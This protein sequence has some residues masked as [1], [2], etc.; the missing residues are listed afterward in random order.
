MTDSI[1]S[2]VT[3]RD[4]ASATGLHHTT[5]SLGLRNSPKL[6]PET[7]QK[8]LRAAEH[9]GYIRDPMLSALNAYR[10][11][12]RPPHYQATIAWINNWPDRETLLE[13]APFRQ[14]YKGACDRAKQFGYVIEEFWLQ[15]AGMSRDRILSILKAQNIQG[16][17]LAP[18]PRA[19]MTSPLD[20]SDFS[21]V[22][23]GYSMQPPVLNVVTNHHFHSM[24]LILSH[25]LK[26]GYRRIGLYVWADWDEKV[27]NA[28]WGGLKLAQWKN[29]ELVPIPPRGHGKV[30][31]KSLAQWLSK[32]KPDVVISYNELEQEI[33]SLGYSVPQDI[34]FASLSKDPNDQVISGVDENSFFIGQKAMDVLVGLLHRGERG[35]PP[36]PTRFLVESTWVPG[37]T[38]RKQE[39]HGGPRSRSRSALH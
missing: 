16:L 34:G 13:I 33:R 29:P 12:K 19:R 6:R 14:Y 15:K 35:I 2:R 36:I 21:A 22:A 20:Y 38:L 23:F 32:Y 5:I 18:Q 24:D 30:G 7:L 8:I 9:L 37:Q 1:K 17:L 28:W 11:S 31:S 26:M 10:Q 4:I 25:L 27:E 39:H 3:V